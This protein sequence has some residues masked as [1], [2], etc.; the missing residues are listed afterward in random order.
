[1]Q[2]RKL[3]TWNQEAC[4]L[5]VVERGCALGHHYL[6]HVAEGGLDCLKVSF[7]L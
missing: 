6:I 7:Q 1:M 5:L 4:H 3:S 2:W